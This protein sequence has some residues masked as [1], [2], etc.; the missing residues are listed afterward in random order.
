MTSRTAIWWWGR[1]H[2]QLTREF[3]GW[4]ATT[5]PRSDGRTFIADVVGARTT[6]CSK[7]RPDDTII[8]NRI[9]NI[10]ENNRNRSSVNIFRFSYVSPPPTPPP[11]L[12]RKNNTRM[13]LLTHKL[14]KKFYKKIP[15]EFSKLYIVMCFANV[16]LSCRMHKIYPFKSIL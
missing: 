13:T 3:A 14:G 5:A 8:I 9:Y 4:M 15:I 6:C 7:G 16:D 11:P 10:I 12:L 1:G 2:Y